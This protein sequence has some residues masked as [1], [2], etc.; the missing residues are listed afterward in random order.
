MA[1]MNHKRLSVP[2]LLTP[3]ALAIALAACSSQPTRV[4]TLDI[5]SMPTQSSQ[6]YLMQADSSEGSLQND[7]LIMALKASLQ[8]GNTQQADL[9]IKRIS[10]QNLS[11]LQQAEWLLQRA[12]LQLINGQP[13]AA[14]SQ[15]NFRQSWTLTDNQWKSYH[16]I[17]IQALN[18]LYSP[19]EV[20]RESIALSKY[21]SN[22]EKA[23][24]A[25]Q[26]WQNLS[27]YSLAELN[28]LPTRASDVVLNDWIE[29][30][31]IMKSLNHS[32]LQLQTTVQQ[33]LNDHDT[34]PANLYTPIA[35]QDVL[36]LE[37]TKPTRTALLLPLTGRFAQQAQLVR[38][39]FI[40]AM[41]E[42]S[43]RDPN[44]TLTVID[45]NIHSADEIKAKVR[46]ANIDFLVGPLVKDNIELL[47]EAQLKSNNPI[48][49]LA[50]N[51]P[52]T[53][54]AGTNTCYLTLSPEQE[55]AQAAK[56]LFEQG[57][58]FPL[59]LAPK[60]SLGERVVDAFKQ[61]WKEYSDHDVAVSRFDKKQQL[62]LNINNAFGLQDSQQRIA[63]IEKLMGVPLETQ[64]RS[65]RDIDAVYIVAKS[66][67]LTLIKPFIEVA[68]NP[69]TKQPQ[70]FANSRSN[71]GS[72]QYEDLTGVIYSDI[73]MLIDE[74]AKLDSSLEPLW[75]NSSNA[76]KRLQALG[77]D[78]YNLMGELPQ[79]KAIEG[80][81][82]KGKTGILTINDQCVV[83]REISWATYGAL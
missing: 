14:Y 18:E 53:I 39:G 10:K 50:L 59:I 19:F 21:L 11:P 9:L 66:S 7:L 3:I 45:T 20:T 72:K 49:A 5:T 52:S 79:M 71:T 4:E 64:A 82:L 29:L 60:D 33:W 15:L 58:E 38:D 12:Q 24:I 23:D 62:Q 37:I 43:D 16:Q 2:R 34:H 73:P 68:I 67:E 55:V 70:L 48:P 22:S 41:M 81:E 1:M 36:A 42:D 76:K 27:S 26:V 75:P 46:E 51:I 13:E 56:Y 69:D 54:E 80:H 32:L 17:R 83:Q 6:S 8:D 77:M 31:T 65:R 57:Y 47:Q 63:Q 40:L 30:A 35:I 44:A 61:Q 74:D 25:E 78:A 28:A